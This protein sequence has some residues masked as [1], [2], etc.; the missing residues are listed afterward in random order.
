MSIYDIINYSTS[1]CPF[2]LGKCEKERKKLQRIEYLENEKSFLNE[3]KTFSM[4]FEDLS[5]DKK[6]LKS[7]KKQRTQA[8][9][10]TSI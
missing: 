3:I 6:K 8:L 2:E 10:H 9:K 4:V 1:I 5:F 7:D